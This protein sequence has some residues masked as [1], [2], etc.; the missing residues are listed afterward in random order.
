MDP[1]SLAAHEV[2]QTVHTVAY[3][4]EVKHR[5]LVTLTDD[6]LKIWDADSTPFVMLLEERG[7]SL[8]LDADWSG[9]GRVLAIAGNS[10]GSIRLFRSPDPSDT[11]WEARAMVDH[12]AAE[13]TW[14]TAVSHRLTQFDPA[15]K[16]EGWGRS[17]QERDVLRARARAVAGAFRDDPVAMVDNAWVNLEEPDPDAIKKG[18]SFA[19]SACETWGEILDN[20]NTVAPARARAALGAAIFRDV[21][22][23]EQAAAQDSAGRPP[24]GPKIEPLS[25]EDRAA[26]LSEAA[27]RLN[28]AHKYLHGRRNDFEDLFEDLRCVAYLAMV[29]SAL[30]DKAGA[31]SAQD[32]FRDSLDKGKPIRN[33]PLVALQREMDEAIRLATP[34]K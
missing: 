12:A 31:I 19:R 25:Q 5:R 34:R 9:D 24:K 2:G 20:G 3:L 26:A 17:D 18:L 30:G 7:E 13:L 29:H 33:E 6:S 16:P 15:R 8:F 11:R 32:E 14:F 1:A 10:N 23:R 4:D 27:R 22:A 28:E 21:Q